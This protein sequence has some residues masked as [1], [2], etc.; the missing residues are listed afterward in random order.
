MGKRKTKGEY[1]DFTEDTRYTKNNN[2]VRT[3][4]QSSS[5]VSRNTSPPASSNRNNNT[6]NKSKA[7]KPPLTHFLC[8]PLVSFANRPRLSQAL[9]EFRSDVEKLT[10]V[11]PQAVRP[12]GTLH[13]TLG[14][15]SLS[16][17]ELSSATQ[18]LQDLD[19]R[20]L[21]RG[22]T[23][24]KIA[25]MGIDTP[26]V[27]EGLGAVEN[28]PPLSDAGNAAAM[29]DPEVLAL[30]LKGLVP[31]QR[32]RQTSILYAEP[33]DGTGRLM[34]FGESLRRSFEEGGWV[35]RDERG[36]R[37]HAT[38]LNTIYAK[39]K[40]R[41]RGRAKQTGRSAAGSAIEAVVRE[42]GVDKQDQRGT[43]GEG[44][45]E[46]DRQGRGADAKNWMRFDASNLIEAY[47]D[48]VWA[49]DVRIDRVQICKMGAQKIRDETNGEIVDERYE[50]VAEKTM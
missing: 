36:L 14:V 22:I 50:V 4:L 7:K 5:T 24:Q 16:P 38:V 3:T 42:D 2:D 41:G 23:T 33:V 34:R 30:D 9:S 25:E 8:L 46:E 21:L 31:M 29:A 47:K 17:L 19:V 49:E 10:P 44:G 27:S 28:P 35:V 18:Y 43:D 1:N 13:L 6:D 40:G 11:P 15:M 12:V 20:R 45:Q 26:T 37:L 48:F 39:P 32:A